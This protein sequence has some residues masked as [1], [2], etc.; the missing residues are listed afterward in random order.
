MAV[1]LVSWDIHKQRSDDYE[2]LYAW[3]KEKHETRL[4]ESVSVIE[5]TPNQA[6]KIVEELRRRKAIKSK[7]R[8]LVIEVTTDVGLYHL[9]TDEQELSDDEALKALRDARVVLTL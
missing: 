1:Y 5:D 8:I 3:L 9:G 2:G 4:L 7:D 6:E